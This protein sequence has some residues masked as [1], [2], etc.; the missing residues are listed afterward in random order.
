MPINSVTD[1]QI[2]IA[3]IRYG[4]IFLWTLGQKNQIDLIHNRINSRRAS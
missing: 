2:L 4:I 1:N 3:L